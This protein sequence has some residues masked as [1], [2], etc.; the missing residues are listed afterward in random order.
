MFPIVG[1][2]IHLTGISAIIAILVSIVVYFLPTIIALLRKKQ[3]PLVVVLI[4]IFLGWTFIGW[5]VALV[6]SFTGPT[7][8]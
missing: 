5:I 1:A 7:T 4:N 2:S 3:N 6:M 8:A